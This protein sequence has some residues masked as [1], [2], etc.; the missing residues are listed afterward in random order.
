MK[1]QKKQTPK[2]RRSQSPISRLRQRLLL[3]F[4][5]YRANQ[6]RPYII[7][8]WVLAP[9]VVVLIGVQLGVNVI[10]TGEVLGEKTRISNQVL[11]S[12][13]NEI[14]KESGV[15]ELRI[16][17]NL[18]RA[19]QLKARDMIKNQYWAHISPSGVQPWS[20]VDESGYHYKSA[21]ENLAK[22]FYSAAAITQAWYDSPAHRE[23][24]LNP[25]FIDVGFSTVEGVIHGEHVILTVALYGEPQ[26]AGAIAA[27]APIASISTDKISTTFNSA[28]TYGNLSAFERIGLAIQSIPPSA[29][30][31]MFI[32]IVLMFT[33]LIAQ[34]YRYQQPASRHKN[35]L[36]KHHGLA[37]SMGLGVMVVSILLVYGGGQI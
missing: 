21:G 26:F 33:A 22:N 32:V 2:L 18:T 16:N 23:N 6:Y 30:A 9:L 17:H 1:T 13:A 35:I 25:K 34:L 5:P 27:A 15:G 4:V 29:L 3:L 11:L 8:S 24:L 37:K 10:T 12:T 36:H 7:R 20:W 31:G 28:G 19:A 14:R